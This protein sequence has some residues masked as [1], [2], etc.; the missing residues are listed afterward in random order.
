MLCRRSLSRALLRALMR[1]ILDPACRPNLADLYGPLI[2]F[3]LRFP[4]DSTA[5]SPVPYCAPLTPPLDLAKVGAP[6]KTRQEAGSVPSM[7]GGQCAV[8]VCEVAVQPAG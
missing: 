3:S 6:S 4:L 2:G 5:S 8:C 7:T 1:I